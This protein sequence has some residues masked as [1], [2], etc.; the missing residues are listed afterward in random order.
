MEKKV[1]INTDTSRVQLDLSKLNEKELKY[2]RMIKPRSGVLFLTSEPGIAKSAIMRCIAKKLGLFYIDLR[3]SMLDETDVGLFPDKCEIEVSYDGKTHV[4]E[5]FLTHLIPEWA[6]LANQKPTLIHFEELNR[7][8]LSVRN[9]ALQILL[10]RGIGFNFQF[11]DN[12]YMVSTG[13][14]GE[15]DGTDVEEFDSALN[16]RLIH[17]QHK[18]SLQEWIDYFAKEHVHSAIVKFLT[19]HSEYYY[20]SRK[21]RDE[22]HKAY[23]TPRSWTFLSDYIVENFG[24]NANIR[25]FVT[26]ISIVGHAF[27]G[28]ANS[29]FVRWCND[30]LKISIDDIINNYGE[31][32]KQK[33]TF[34]RDKKSELLSELREREIVGYKGKQLENIKLFLIEFGN[35]DEVTAYLIHILDNQYE[36]HEDEKDDDQY[37]LNQILRDPRFIEYQK[38]IYDHVDEEEKEDTSTKKKDESEW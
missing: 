32:K 24:K 20:I 36:W 38:V 11:N 26:D 9:A 30:Y 6:W 37:L 16:G 7:A 15:E 33:V 8:P 31:L 19:Q 29:H 2:F 10:E 17:Y 13:N 1:K 21:E 5:K 23:A 3:L 34:T 35:K 22:K 12:V 27:V 25:D 18:L 14:L 4:K 28:A